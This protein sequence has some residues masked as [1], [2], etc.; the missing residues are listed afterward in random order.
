M[1]R[2]RGLPPERWR[3]GAR[4]SQEAKCFSVGHRGHVE[5]DLAADGDGGGHVDGIDLG[6]VDLVLPSFS[7][8]KRNPPVKGGAAGAGGRLLE[9]FGDE[10]Q[11][12]HL[13]LGLSPVFPACL[14]AM[15]ITSVVTC[16]TGV[17]A[18]A[19]A[20]RIRRYGDQRG[21]RVPSKRRNPLTR[22]APPANVPSLGVHG[23]SNATLGK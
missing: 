18:T 6:E 5:A 23:A 7:V 13:L 11:L 15:M 4:P 1:R 16:Q 14:R 21:L 10:A 12:A 9:R 22:P 19:S 2:L 3:P 8:R 17:L 20:G